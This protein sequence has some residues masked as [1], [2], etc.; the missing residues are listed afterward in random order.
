[1][2][3][4]AYDT[5][6]KVASKANGHAPRVKP[7]R[8]AFVVSQYPTGGDTFITNQITGLLDLG[9]DVEIFALAP[10]QNLAKL[11]EDIVQYKLI[12]RVQY[13]GKPLKRSEEF[14]T[15]ARD[16]I[17]SPLRSG[18]RLLESRS[19]K[20]IEEPTPRFDGYFKLRTFERQKPFDIINVH[21][22]PIANNMLFLKELFPDTPFVANFHGY[23]FSSRIRY[24]GLN[25]YD[26]LWKKADLVTSHSFFSRDCLMEIGCPPEIAVKHPLGIDV[27]PFQYR[28]RRL[29]PGAP[30]QMAIVARLAEKKS[31]R[32][33]LG[34][35]DRL[36]KERP[37]IHLHVV[38]SGD[39][40]E[41]IERQIAASERL[42]RSVTL[43]GW[44]TQNEVAAILDRCHIFLH[45]ST[46]S[47]RWGEQEDT[48][49]GI[50]EA[51]AMGLP[52]IAT[53][54]AG[55]PEIVM[56]EETG[57]LVPERNED[58]LL[59]AMREMVDHPERWE[60]MGSRGRDLVM[61]N[62][63]VRLLNARLEW[64]FDQLRNKRTGADMG[65]KST[66]EL[67][68]II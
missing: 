2:D 4:I 31:H 65:I 20:R 34:A 39:L 35:L 52:V 16:F 37:N 54:H 36:L 10:Q 9:H 45:P 22:G 41:P 51:Q 17:S 47:M 66:A 15:L 56:H 25:Y 67:R 48:P 42:T 11:H 63:D 49:T 18:R 14:S 53:Y 60:E 50:I 5:E 59:D 26:K 32:I 58:S 46:A 40:K 23:D 6:M 38:G 62:F 29:E 57:L 19:V 55:I 64:V 33:I 7:M 3:S 61:N 1:M 68:G 28:P 21:F 43:H 12:D 24:H 44:K 13:H 8:V 30:V 27:R